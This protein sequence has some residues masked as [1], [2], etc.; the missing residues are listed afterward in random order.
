MKWL[1]TPCTKGIL[2]NAKKSQQNNVPGLPSAEPCRA[3]IYRTRRTLENPYI[4]RRKKNKNNTPTNK[5]KKHTTKKKIEICQK[6]S[7]TPLLSFRRFIVSATESATI[8][9]TT[10]TRFPQ[11]Y[12]ISFCILGP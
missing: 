3:T 10:I 5:E 6:Q 4:Y 11:E 2:I 9:L 1:K 8:P 12:E 7:P